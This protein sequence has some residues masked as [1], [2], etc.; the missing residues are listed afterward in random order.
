MEL[1]NFRAEDYIFLSPQGKFTWQ[2]INVVLSFGVLKYVEYLV[3]TVVGWKWNVVVSKHF[4]GL[5]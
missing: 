5:E 2:P 4:G 1:A 3:R